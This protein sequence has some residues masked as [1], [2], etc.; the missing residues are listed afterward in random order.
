MELYRFDTHVHTAEVSPCGKVPAREVVHLY[1]EAGYDGIVITDH[2][3]AGLFRDTHPSEWE[4][5]VDRYLEG[6]RTARNEG[7]KIGLNVILGIELRFEGHINDYLVFGVDEE[8][9]KEHPNLPSL[10]LKGFKKLIEGKDILV[11]QAHPFR[12]GMIP[13]D[14]DLLDGIEV[15]N[16]HPGQMSNNPLALEYAISNNLKMISGSDFHQVPHLARGGIVL[17]EKIDTPREL[18]RMLKE[19]RIISLIRAEDEE[20]D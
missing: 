10:G 18:V 11:Y 9:L 2:Y 15:Y 14:P 13:S 8:F 7:K 20:K 17:P 19:D 12:P 16:G 4:A 3:T 6:Y 5:V 1:K